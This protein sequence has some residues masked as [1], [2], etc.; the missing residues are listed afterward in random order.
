VATLLG[1]CAVSSVVLEADLVAHAVFV[2][3][4]LLPPAL[5]LLTQ[6]DPYSLYGGVG[7]LSLMAVM[8]HEGRRAQ[9]RFTELVTLRHATQVIAEERAAALQQAEQSN[10]F[11]S[12]FL[13]QLSH[14]LRTPLHGILGLSRMVRE[15]EANEQSKEQLRLLERSGRHLLGVI[16]DVL[17]LSKIEAG[18]LKMSCE[19]FDLSR[20]VDDVVAL[21]GVSATHKGLELRCENKLA[22]PC[23]VAGDAARVRQVLLNLVGN[24][25]KFTDAG[26]VT[27]RVTADRVHPENICLLVKDTG[28]GMT[29]ADQQCIF[30]AFRQLD[31][32]RGRIPGTG[33][34]LTISRELAR[35]MGGDVSCHS[36]LGQGS[37]FTFT[38]KL[39]PAEAPA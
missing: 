5:F 34:G 20:L 39:P 8:F 22:R 25:I 6:H 23:W 13:A 16:N 19:P 9:R 38:V 2:A 10:A 30:E 12:R 15:R 33:L 17:D 1:V 3:G 11:K 32:G 35:A 14:E 26:Q 28:T 31:N 7:V 36:M 27:L 18:R 37:E 21:S 4:L 29:P 24:A